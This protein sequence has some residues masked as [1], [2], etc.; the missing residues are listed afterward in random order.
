MTRKWTSTNTRIVKN[1]DSTGI[2][3]LEREV[4]NRGVFNGTSDPSSQATASKSRE[5]ILD[6]KSDISFPF[7]VLP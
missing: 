7:N 5:K 2:F 4:G 3:N 6:G 1:K